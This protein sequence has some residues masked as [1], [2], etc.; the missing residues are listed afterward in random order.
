M[1]LKRFHPG[2]KCMSTVTGVTAVGAGM[3]AGM[4][5]GVGVGVS[6]GVGV[7]VGTGVSVGVSVDVG[8]VPYTCTQS[9]SHVDLH[10]ENR[11]R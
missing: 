9:P 10:P 5:V 3:K 8:I 2:S 7:G 1:K 4:A 11:S 6:V